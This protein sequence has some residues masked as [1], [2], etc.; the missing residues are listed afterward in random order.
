M[1]SFLLS[2][3]IVNREEQAW[4][5]AQH[6]GGGDLS[7]LTRWFGSEPYQDSAHVMS[8]G[9]SNAIDLQDNVSVPHVDTE[10]WYTQKKHRKMAS[11][12]LREAFGLQH[13]IAVLLVSCITVAMLGM[14]WALR[15][16]LGYWQG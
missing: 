6:D 3:C 12:R 10:R 13:K 4:R 2:L 14:F 16:S 9:T 7:R 1:V 11:Y 15:K 8:A 5:V